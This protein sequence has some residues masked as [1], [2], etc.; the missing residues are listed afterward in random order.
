MW[1]RIRTARQAYLTSRGAVIADIKAGHVDDAQQKLL[2]EQVPR[3][4]DY[5]NAVQAL[6]DFVAHQVSTDRDASVQ[7]YANGRDFVMM[8]AALAVAVGTI[9]SV[10]VT[11]SIVQSG[12]A[13]ADKCFQRSAPLVTASQH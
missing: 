11:R 7:S 8:L 5:L 2:S 6:I 4:S 10:L 3:E 13:T 1:E 9:C 12:H